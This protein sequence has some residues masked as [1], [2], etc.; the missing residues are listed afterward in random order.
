[1]KRYNLKHNCL[2]AV[3]FTMVLLSGCTTKYESKEVPIAKNGDPIFE[4]L[5]DVIDRYYPGLYQES[6]T[7]E[8]RAKYLKLILTKTYHYDGEIDIQSLSSS[9]RLGFPFIDQSP[10][11]DG[12][13]HYYYSTQGMVLQPCNDT[14][15]YDSYDQYPIHNITEDN[16]KASDTYP[17]YVVHFKVEDL[18][19]ADYIKQSSEQEDLCLFTKSIGGGWD[20]VWTFSSNKLVYTADEI[21]ALMDEYEGLR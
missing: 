18:I 5:Y 7:N 19:N 15:E 9:Y 21:N 8:I 6:T 2:L 20:L 17:N 10:I 1:M 16:S 4:T 13:M 3:V 11:S 12:S 14:L